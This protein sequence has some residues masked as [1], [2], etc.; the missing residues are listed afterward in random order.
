[1]NQSVNSLK[2]N[3]RV[4]SARLA[5]VVV[6]SLCVCLLR[7]AGAR[8]AFEQVGTFAGSAAPVLEE[9]FSEEVQLGGVSGMA[10]N[11]T[12]AGGVPAGTVYAATYSMYDS[13]GLRVAVFKPNG[14]G[15]LTFSEAW[16]VD[17]LSGEPYARC[18]PEGEPAAPH[19]SIRSGALAEETDV[20]VDQTTGNVYVETDHHGSGAKR[21]VVY[22]ADGSKEI[23]RFGETDETHS[24]A[25]SPEK[26]HSPSSTDG[27]AVDGE[28][29]VYVYDIDSTQ[30]HS[31]LMVFRP[32]VAGDYE[33]Y[34]YAG[35][36]LAGDAGGEPAMPVLD[37]AGH[38]Y[39][40]SGGT[41][42]EE[43]GV[44][45]PAG[46]PASLVSPVC[47]FRFVK[48]GI[49]SM[50]VDPATGE[51]FFY[52]YRS[53]KGVHRLGPCDEATGEF[54]EVSPEPEAFGVAPERGELTALA[55][56]PVRRLESS[57]APGV[58]YGGAAEPVP[59]RTLGTG[60]PGQSSLGYVFSGAKEVSPSVVSESVSG[61][62]GMGVVLHATIDPHGFD[63]HYVFQY[64]TLAEYEAN[65][66][67]ERF[68]GAGEAPVGG[69]LLRGGLGVQGVAVSVDGLAPE[70]EYRYRVFAGS[71]CA[72]GKTCEGAGETEAFSTFPSVPAGLPDH[73][74]YELV[75]PVLKDGGQ[76]FPAEPEISSCG[77][78]IECKPGQGVLHFSMQSAPNGNSVVFEGSPFSEGEGAIRENEYVARR[79]EQK[80]WQTVN[81]TP[82]VLHTLEGSY[83]AFD[84]ALG[85]GVLYQ[86]GE[87][88]PTLSPETPAG[89]PDLYE[90][91][92]TD[93]GSVVPLVTVAPPNRG[94]SSFK[95]GYAGHSADFSRQFFTAN[96]ALTGETSFAPAAVDGGVSENN[97][98]EREEDGVLRLVNVLPGNTQTEPGSAYGSVNPDA[99]AI[100]SDGRRVFWSSASGQV[101][102][103]EDGERTREIP[104]HAGRFL[105]ASADGSR[106]LLTDGNVY[107]LETEI[108]TDLTN[109][110]GGFQGVLGQSEDLSH[111][112]FVDT[113][114]LTSLG[115]ENANHEHAVEGEDN[116][117]AWH[118]AQPVFIATLL[119]GDDQGSGGGNT[120]EVSRIGDWAN[121][122][123][124]RT[125]EAS[126]NGRFVAFQSMARLT[127][128]DNTGP[129]KLLD[130][131]E[132]QS[133]VSGPCTEVFL[134]DS[135]ADTLTCASCNPTG[136][137]T[138]GW[139]VLRQIN[140][141]NET[142]L[143]QP[144]YLTNEGRLVFDTQESLSPHDT[145]EGVEDVYEYEPKGVGALGTCRRETGCVSLISA[146]TGSVDS[147][148]LA[149]DE[150]GKNI[151]FTTR[152]RLSSRDHDD[153]TD[154]YDAR[155]GG[156]T[157][158]ETQGAASEC[159]CQVLPTPPPN[160]TTPAS[161][162]FSGP[163]DLISP[164]PS[165]V[166]VPKKKTVTQ[167]NGVKLAK[168]LKACHKLSKAKRKR[169]EATARKR[170]AKGSQSKKAKPK[171]K[172]SSE[173]G[174][175]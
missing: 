72:L 9:H 23:A 74:V 78:S 8:A 32:Q 33:H 92:T 29:D 54:T 110:K 136:E 114:A 59:P 20:E 45:V 3:R 100:S 109:G 150:D 68:A 4:V 113:A 13:L 79:D 107:D 174:G 39:V 51:V 145:N 53:P 61:V 64:L 129:C 56:D 2:V 14:V 38:V 16:G 99:H 172:Q 31:R 98:Y 141:G 63:T 168:A 122:P 102:V 158:A 124:S 118:E 147:N 77:A 58:L 165:T 30:L 17:S 35:E 116:L 101:Y 119:S 149:M 82:S 154:L 65:P 175:K 10:V 5:I 144:R 55:F 120:K 28:G 143:P 160:E 103:R 104:D 127:G 86:P 167:T 15:G 21:M 133:Y 22:S 142:Y 89:Y 162:L 93:P 139:S 49:S 41:N 60:E 132:G 26:I 111:V 76:V 85:Q 34:V 12:G 117:Y 27:L 6:M 7:V 115:E 75:S 161:V 87:P 80:G 52:S 148:F 25:E 112:Y 105:S 163:G 18:G 37:A 138:L 66:S 121:S 69:G 83:D 48:G 46:Y 146:G 71:E 164:L 153:L 88:Y 84:G 36:V 126:P 128:H 73:R 95:L 155:E 43:F 62:G 47:R 67:G 130:E 44:G 159:G 135:F 42:V 11:T 156:G 19:C 152:D 81:L 91:S 134:Y 170:Y 169:C 125:A 173:K 131:P 151:F 57:R 157:P 123:A 97:L 1:M 70:T 108:I 90:Q 140:T 171:S 94:P 96:D 40:V 24:V 50:T 106:V 166:V 137:H